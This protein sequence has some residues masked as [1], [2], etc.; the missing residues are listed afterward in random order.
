MWGP[1]GLAEAALAIWG[2]FLSNSAL[3]SFFPSRA[4]REKLILE[5]S[6]LA[7]AK[8]AGCSQAVCWG[9]Q[10]VFPGDWAVPVWDLHRGW[11]ARGRADSTP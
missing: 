6:G 11:G 3:S 4:C 10:G 9:V 5:L 1:E 8:A 2:T 7:E